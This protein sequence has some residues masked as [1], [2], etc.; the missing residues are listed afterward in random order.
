MRRKVLTTWLVIF[1]HAE[2]TLG[3]K[4]D[5]PGQVPPKVLK[6]IL[7]EGYFCDDELSAR[8]L[9]RGLGLLSERGNSRR[10]A[11]LPLLA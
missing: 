8:V 11:G 6:E 3:T 9:R 5:E 1:K 4:I 2:T 10:S 7:L